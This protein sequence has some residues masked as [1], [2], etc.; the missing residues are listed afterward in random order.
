[1]IKQEKVK[2]GWPYHFRRHILAEMLSGLLI[3]VPFFIGF[4]VL[5]FA[6]R[7]ISSAISPILRIGIYSGIP[8][9]IVNL[10]SV[11]IL[12]LILYLVGVLAKNS[13]GKKVAALTE[14][15]F[16]KIPVFKVIFSASKTAISAMSLNRDASFHSVVFIEFPKEGY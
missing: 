11:V 12:L 6:F 13:F 5:L 3:L 9:E 7:M 8:E 16:L 4:F 2:G 14:T 1:M 15:M 10:L